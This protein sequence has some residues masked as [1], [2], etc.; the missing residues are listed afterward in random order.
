MPFN[1]TFDGKYIRLC[2]INY[3]HKPHYKKTNNGHFKN[4]QGLLP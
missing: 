2:L 1:F 3:I 4:D